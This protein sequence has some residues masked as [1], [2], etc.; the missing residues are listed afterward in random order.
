MHTQVEL[1]LKVRTIIFISKQKK[2]LVI[3]GYKALK[4]SIDNHFSFNA[5]IT[6]STASFALDSASRTLSAPTLL[7]TPS[8]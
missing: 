1:F 3:L 7:F 2:N 5:S 4:H 8:R 6:K